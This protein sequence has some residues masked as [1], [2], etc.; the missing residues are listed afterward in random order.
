[1]VSGF[2]VDEFIVDLF[3][4]FDKS[5]KRKNFMQEYCHFCDHSYRAIVKHVSTPWLSLELA[6]ECGLKQLR[7]L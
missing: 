3:Y 2:D 4:W 1:M 5:T 7:G 6:I